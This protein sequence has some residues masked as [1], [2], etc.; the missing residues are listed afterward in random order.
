MAS[1]LLVLCVFSSWL[2]NTKRNWWV[3]VQVG[4]NNAKSLKKFSSHPRLSVTIEKQS[5][6]AISLFFP[7]FSL[8]FRPWINWWTLGRKKKRD[9]VPSFLRQIWHMR[10]NISFIYRTIGLLLKPWLD[11]SLLP[12]ISVSFS[13]FQIS[14]KISSFPV[15]LH[16][17]H[18]RLPLSFS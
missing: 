5:V 10:R 2:D 8:A 6:S 14:G 9:I 11:Y 7:F 18:S 17:I 1:V 16:I 4:R 13:W 3:N 15:I 12:L